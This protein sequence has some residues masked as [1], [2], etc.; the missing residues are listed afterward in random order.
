[1]LGLD[2]VQIA[3]THNSA[4]TAGH[5]QAC[6]SIA[7]TLLENVHRLI[8]DLRPTLLDDLGLV[9]AIKWYGAQR[10]NPLGIAFQVDDAELATRL[11]PALETVFFRVIQEAITNIVRHAHA[12]QVTVRLAT[13]GADTLLQITDNG[14]GFDPQREQTEPGF[15]LRGMQERVEIL[16]GEFHLRAIG[17]RG[18]AH[19]RLDRHGLHIHL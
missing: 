11:P 6:K 4:Q 13:A 16:G 14:Q 1:M 18:C 12:T 19:C 15:G 17:C 3:Q 5:L 7:D 8:A 9:P 10:L 2:T